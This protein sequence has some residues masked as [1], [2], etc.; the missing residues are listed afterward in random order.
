[1]IIINSDDFGASESIN[2]ATY[3]ALKEKLISSTTALVNFEKGFEDAVKYVKTG[4]ISPDVVGIHL[5]LTEGAPLTDRMKRNDTFCEGGL[6]KGL[7]AIPTFSM[8]RE[9]RECVYGELDAQIRH[10]IEKFGF[11]PSHIDSHQHVHTKWAIM[12]CVAKVAKKHNLLAIRPSR[13]LNRNND[14]KKRLYKSLF[15]KYLRLKGF[16][17]TDNFGDLDEAIYCGIKPNR[18]YEIM[19]H[20]DFDKKGLEIRDMDKIRLKR[21]LTKLKKQTK[22]KLGSYRIL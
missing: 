5:N 21:K 12:Q 10:F 9:S 4:K 14:Y 11:L 13:N 8:D 3:Y 20:V 15:N 22:L 18:K 19:V 6:F 2:R 16:K 1:M 17:T 7:E